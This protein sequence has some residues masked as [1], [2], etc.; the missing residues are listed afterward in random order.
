MNIEQAI[1]HATEEWWE[2]LRGNIEVETLQERLSRDYS[3]KVS[4]FDIKRAR[5][6]NYSLLV[7][8]AFGDYYSLL[9]PF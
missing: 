6:K 7:Q 5:A 1:A 9:Q 3:F 4:M 8:D 2:Y